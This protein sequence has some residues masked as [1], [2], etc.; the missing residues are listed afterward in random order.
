MLSLKSRRGDVFLST[1]ASIST[2]YLSIVARKTFIEGSISFFRFNRSPYARKMEISD[3]KLLI[4]IRGDLHITRDGRIGT[5]EKS[6][7]ITNTLVS[8]LTLDV[9]RNIINFGKVLSSKMMSIKAKNIYS[10]KECYDDTSQRYYT[11]IEK[12]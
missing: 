10:C 4:R 1:E 5:N 2:C 6:D 12:R 8:K 9:N 3:S 11:I 7:R